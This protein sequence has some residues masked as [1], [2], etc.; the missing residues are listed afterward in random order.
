MNP[1]QIMGLATLERPDPLRRMVASIDY[2]VSELWIVNNSQVLLPELANPKV[3]G[4]VEVKGHQCGLMRAWN[5]II[6]TRS[7]VDFW[8]LA[9]DDIEFEPGA[10]QKMVDAYEASD[11]QH[12]IWPHAQTYK[13]FIFPRWCRDNIGFFDEQFFPGYFGDWDITKRCQI[14]GVNPITVESAIVKHRDHLPS[15]SVADFQKSKAY[16]YKKW[17]LPLP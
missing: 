12:I 7:D 10:I 4:V 6:R 1:I 2:D 13:A 8:F 14:A 5:L 11:K 17:N 16:Y 15:S 3:A 9:V